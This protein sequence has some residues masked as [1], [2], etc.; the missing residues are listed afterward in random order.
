MTCR[1][2]PSSWII[3][4]FESSFKTLD[5]IEKYQQKFLKISC[6]IKQRSHGKC[7][8]CSVTVFLIFD[9]EKN[10]EFIVF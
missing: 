9:L 8:V 4:S 3:I 2:R 10:V 6:L 5:V 1:D 7:D